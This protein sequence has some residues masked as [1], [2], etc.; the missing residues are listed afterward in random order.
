MMQIVIRTVITHE[1]M[2]TCLVRFMPKVAI[3]NISLSVASKSLVT[4]V[5]KLVTK[6]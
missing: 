6:L 5:A 4:S 2:R 3:N 1:F